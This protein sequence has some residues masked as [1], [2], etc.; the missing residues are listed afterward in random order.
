VATL[1]RGLG[2]DEARSAAD[3]KAQA[4]TR[5]R[6]ASYFLARL[7]NGELVRLRLDSR[8]AP[9]VVTATGESILVESLWSTQRDQVY[10]SVC[11][12]LVTALGRHGARLPLVLDEP[13]VR[14]DAQSGAALVEVLG[15]FCAR[16]HQVLAFTSRTEAAERILALGA[17]VYE[18]HALRDDRVSETKPLATEAAPPRVR[19]RAKTTRMR[20]R[21]AG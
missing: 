16:G 11:L 3:A 9:R 4:R 10:L 20:H 1:V 2:T 12:S 17:N 18:M 6:R 14:M 5:K 21:E 13:F 8:G 19:R 15:G 7:T